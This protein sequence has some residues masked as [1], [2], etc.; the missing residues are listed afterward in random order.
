MKTP[1]GRLPV[2]RLSNPHHHVGV[3]RQYGS[4]QVAHPIGRIGVVAVGHDVE[5]GI[6]L[7]EHCRD[8][9]A[10]ALFLFAYHDRPGLPGDL[11]GSISAVV[12]KDIDGGFGDF[13]LKITDDFI[14]RGCLV[15]A[16]HQDGDCHRVRLG[17]GHA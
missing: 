17:I 15:V 8:H 7:L 14:D 13:S 3:A 11:A 9:V 12:V 5:V 16:G 1:V 10:L 4:K 2:G 6:N